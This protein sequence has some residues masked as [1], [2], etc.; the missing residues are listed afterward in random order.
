MR[1]ATAHV[2]YCMSPMSPPVFHGTTGVLRKPTFRG[3]AQ[4]QLRS[5]VSRLVAPDFGGVCS[6]AEQNGL[7]ERSPHVDG[8]D[9]GSKVRATGQYRV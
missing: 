7:A 2:V 5:V 9:D 8:V 4:R 3:K 6:Q 1:H